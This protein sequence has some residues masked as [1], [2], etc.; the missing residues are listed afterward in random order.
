VRGVRRFDIMEIPEVRRPPRE[1]LYR[2]HALKSE[3]GMIAAIEPETGEWFL[4]EN[5]IEAFKKARSGCPEGTFYFVRVG[6]PSAHV[7]KE[8]VSLDF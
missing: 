4:G 3:K 6:Y 8:T 5:V 1:V 2:V 7:H